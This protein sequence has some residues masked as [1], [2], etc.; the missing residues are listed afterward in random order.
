MHVASTNVIIC[1]LECF[2]SSLEKQF[3][4]SFNALEIDIVIIIQVDF[5]IFHLT[6]QLNFLLSWKSIDSI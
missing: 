1:K 2:C 5:Y 6:M 3:I 4:L